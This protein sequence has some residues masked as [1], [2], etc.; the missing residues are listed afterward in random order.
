M[1]AAVGRRSYDVIALP[2]DGIGPEVMAAA[3]TLLECAEQTFGIDFSVTELPVGGSSIDK[4][5]VP[6]LP[7]SSE[8]H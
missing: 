6:L 5:G 7:D 1:C 2:G 4:H 3:L 8:R